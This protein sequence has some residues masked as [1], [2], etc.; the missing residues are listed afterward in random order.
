MPTRDEVLALIYTALDA[1]NEMYDDDKKI[2]ITKA[3]ESLLFNKEFALDSLSLISLVVEIEESIEDNFDAEIM[4][5][6]DRAMSQ[7]FSPF[8]SFG[9]LADYVM[10]LLKEAND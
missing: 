10:V 3:E 1:V 7:K 5:A 4:L 9:T 6:D 2:A 8:H